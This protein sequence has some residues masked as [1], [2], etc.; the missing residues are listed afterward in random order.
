LRAFCLIVLLS[1]L[2]SQN[3]PA[4]QKY[5]PALIDDSGL[6]AA[7]ENPT[8]EAER[9]LETFRLVW[10]TVKDNYF[11]QTFGG[12]NWN[13]IKNEFEPRAR[14]SQTDAELHLILQEMIN[15]LNKSHFM[16]IP[17][18]VFREIGKA[19][20]EFEEKTGAA[21]AETGTGEPDASVEEEEEE[22]PE[23][24][25]HYGIGIDIRFINNQVVI[26]QVEKN[27]PA[28]NA[29]LKTGYVIEKINGV[30]LK[31]FLEK[32]RQNAIYAKVYEK[33]LSGLLLSIIDGER[34]GGSVVVGYRNEREQAA[35]I[36]IERAAVKGEFVKIISGLPAEFTTFESKS[37]GEEIGY[38]KFNVFALKT[39]EK[40]CGAI[41]RLKDKRALVVDMRGNMGGNFGALFGIVSLLTD[42]GLII[43]SE[44][45]K[46]GKEPRFVQPQLKNFK[47]RLVILTDAQSYSAAEVFASGLKENNRATVIGETTAGSALPALTM[48]LPTGAV[49][50]YPV[51]N[52]ETPKG[53]LLEGKGVEPNIKIA[54]D[55]P[56]L[57]A[58]KD[59]QL[60]AAINFL[61]GELAKNPAE[62]VKGGSAVVAPTK[63][64][65]LGSVTVTLAST[66]KPVKD[67][68][69]LK[70]IDEYLEIIG[71]RENLKKLN[72]L[73]ATG[74]VEMKQA[75]ATVEGEVEIYRKFPNKIAKV[76]K[77]DGLGEIN[78][79]FDGAKSF[80]QTDFMGT[81]KNEFQAGEMNLAANFRELLDAREL[82]QSITFESVFENEGRKINL[83]KAVAK[84]GTTVY[85][86]FDTTTKLLISRAGTATSAY[87]ADYRKVGEWLFPFQISESIVTYKLKEI[88]PNAPVEDSRFLE[89]E[90]CFT[91]ID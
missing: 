46:F 72:S 6:E 50:L 35:E 78:E 62:N 85:F 75:G 13:K 59:A 74:R 77:I 10:Q 58:G 29:G 9:R 54:L 38:I 45:N 12:L 65:V 49:F 32:F 84:Q 73:A 25:A 51:A 70:I 48:Q 80:V 31:T 79:V 63:P 19:K 36:E 56:S 88:K 30:S 91:K 20:A 52:F 8:P 47:G 1:A 26:T 22:T 89:K 81:Q 2:F 55:R 16:I 7:A 66:V 34:D 27:S 76:L 43:G 11:D 28:A 15:R 71:G 61:K 67:E 18:E 4:Q 44:I 37:L 60:D 57:L 33:Q 83:V 39:V 21:E 3:L 64:V 41:S 24:P 69:A 40:F 68:K 53:N 42:K 86:A 23:K 5:N 87:Y 90:S 14:H 82:Y 17:P